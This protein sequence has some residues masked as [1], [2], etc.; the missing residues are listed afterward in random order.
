MILANKETW[1][2]LIANQDPPG[3][4]RLVTLAL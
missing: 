2:T 3:S 1:D 4:G